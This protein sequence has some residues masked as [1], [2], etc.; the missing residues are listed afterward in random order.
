MNLKAKIAARA[1]IYDA[2]PH[3]PT[4]DKIAEEIL[5]YLKENHATLPVED[6]IET[7]THLGGAPSILYD[8]NGHFTIGGDG[9]QN[10]PTFEDDWKIK[11]TTFQGT[12]FV[13]PG[14]WKDTIREA[15]AAYFERE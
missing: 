14:G 10:M 13:E 1:A 5:H 9:I 2:N 8:D 11:E 3:N 6:I 15:L 4:V 12:W 7:L